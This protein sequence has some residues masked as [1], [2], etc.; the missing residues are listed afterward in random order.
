[1]RASRLIRC[2][3]S[4][5]VMSTLWRHSGTR[6]TWFWLLFGAVVYEL[7]RFYSGRSEAAPYSCLICPEHRQIRFFAVLQRKPGGPLGSSSR[8]EAMHGVRPVV[9]S[10]AHGVVIDNVSGRRSPQTCQ[11]RLKGF[12]EV[13]L[14]TSPALVRVSR[15]PKDERALSVNII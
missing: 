9:D 1:M 15:H 3:R 14:A 7:E 2:S 13:G 6:L 5:R 8:R 12:G 11:V 4:Y 10:H